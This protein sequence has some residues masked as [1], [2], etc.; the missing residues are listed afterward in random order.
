MLKR[1]SPFLFAF[2][3]VQCASDKT[4]ELTPSSR[5][6]PTNLEILAIELLHKAYERESAKFE[7]QE[8]A[9]LDP[10]QLEIQ[11]TTD[12]KK[13]AFW[14]NLYNAQVQ[15]QLQK[16]SAQFNDRNAFYKNPNLIVAGLTLSLDEIEHIILRRSKG[17]YSLGYLPVLFSSA[18]SKKWRVDSVDWRI[19]FALNCGAK[20]CPPIAF[21]R[22][23]RL[24]EQ[25]NVAS[26]NYLLNSVDL[27][28]EPLGIPK[29]FLWFRADFGGAKGIT[30]ILQ[31]FGGIEQNRAKDWQ[32]LPYDWELDL[33]QWYAPGALIEAPQIK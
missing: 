2:F 17:K 1:I 8:L 12:A 6:A 19:H 18:H 29:L 14:V 27:N 31:K 26:R 10:S 22:S 15:L 13:M 23:D 21:Y 30:K 16:D 4:T 9:K 33:N 25:F 24:N 11:L 7:I 3:F 28:I 20:S 5:E 32:Y